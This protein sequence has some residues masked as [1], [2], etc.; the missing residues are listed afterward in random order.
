MAANQQ[1]TE[2]AREAIVSG[3]RITEERK[4]AQ[5]EPESLLLALVEQE[6]GIIPQVLQRMQLEPAKIARETTA[7]VDRAPKLQISSDPIVSAGLRRALQAAETEASQ[8]GDEFISTEHLFLGILSVER[9]PAE[10]LLRR[11]GVDRDRTM[12]PRTYMPGTSP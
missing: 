10:S 2:K 11:Y 5:Y 7:L 12:R 4:L 8:F 9:S 3:Q 1:Y 6:D